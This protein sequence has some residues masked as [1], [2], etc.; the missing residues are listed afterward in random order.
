MASSLSFAHATLDW[1]RQNPPKGPDFDWEMY[2]YVPSMAG[3]IV[4]LVV[5]FVMALLHSYQFLKSRNRI[6]VFVVIGALCEVGGYGARIAS[7]FD[8]Q[9]WGPYITQGVLTLVGPLWFA[10]TI[11]MMLGRTIRL[12]GGEDV[13]LIPARW[14]TRIFVTADV[15]TL[16]I[17]GLGAS[18]MGTMQLALALAGEKIVI[19]GLALQVATFIVFLVASFDF[20]IRMNKKADHPSA[21]WKKMLYILYSVSALILFRCTFRLIEYAMGNAAY[22]IAHEW[23]LYCFDAVPMFLVLVL[24]LVLQPSRY[25]EGNLGKPQVDRDPEIGTVERK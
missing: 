4:C 7:H 21:D 10:A 13:S 25:V 1:K 3:A 24:L 15:T 11:Y 5:F 17:Q 22:L 14:Y 6:I 2:R 20:Q 9:A 16:I 19:A 18:I 8:N 23:T 12:A